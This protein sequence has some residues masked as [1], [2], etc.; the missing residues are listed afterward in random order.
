MKQ[1]IVY[2]EISD[3]MNAIY[4]EEGYLT[5]NKCYIITGSHLIY[6]VS[7]LNSKLFTRIVM[8]EFNITGGKGKDMLKNVCIYMPTDEIENP[9]INLFKRRMKGD[10][11][12]NILDDIFYHIYNINDVEKI[13]LNKD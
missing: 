7:Y 12:D 13:M 6:L 1:K 5:D 3:A 8:K 11:V 9:I 4:D 2:R 10:Y